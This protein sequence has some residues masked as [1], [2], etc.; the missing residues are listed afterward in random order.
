MTNA[1]PSD[2]PLMTDRVD[3]VMSEDRVAKF[4][5]K[6]APG[7]RRALQSRAQDAAEWLVREYPSVSDEALVTTLVGVLPSLLAGKLN[8]F[9]SYKGKDKQIAIQI[10]KKL[11]VWSDRK[12]KMNHMA[13]LGVEEVGHAWREKIEKTIPLCDWF[14][15]L[16]PNPG[17]E[18]DWVLF[19][20]GYFFRGQGLAGR[21]VCLHHPDNEVADALGEHQSV[22]AETDKVQAF[23]EGL[24]HRPN[25]IPGMPPLNPDLD[26]LDV[27][28]K[29][30]VDLIKPPAIPS[31]RSCCGP[32]ME[33]AFDDASTV[34]GWEQLAVGRVIDW[35]EDCKRLFGLQVHKPSFGDWVKK[36]EGAGRDEGWVI[37]LAC[38]VQA[39]A[40]GNEVPAIR[41]TFG[42]S[43][44]RR[45]RPTICAVRRRKSD[46]RV[47]AVDILF[48]ETA[49]P[50]ETSGM[51]PELACLAITLQFAV[52]LRYQ[53]L[54]HYVGR[55]LEAKDVLTFNRAVNE[56]QREAVRDRRFAEHPS[57]IRERTLALFVGEDK[58]VV[59]TMYE[60][61]DQTDLRLRSGV[62]FGGNRLTGLELSK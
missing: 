47:E 1:E 7:E 11:E 29:E 37:E 2:V 33:V 32:H 58:A 9:F 28:A 42:L 51:N 59:R 25:W 40:E 45:V 26:Q 48:S 38:A 21:L 30:I 16:L 15:L 61:S 6:N 44:R 39:A 17:D 57:V 13:D 23:L 24:F 4:I 5:S 62:G 54:E 52:R 41:A 56:I 19:E 34:R 35:N 53:L 20:A 3:R 12:L 50:P 46:Q 36:V 31:V 10:A 60:R 49:L 22:P 27:K 55:K 18:R 43:D 8:V 14:L